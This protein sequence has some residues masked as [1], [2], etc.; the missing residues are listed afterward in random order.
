MRKVL[1]VI[2]L[3]LISTPITSLCDDDF[4]LELFM[5]AILAGAVRQGESQV[6]GPEGGMFE[7]AN[8]IILSVPSGALTQIVTI[9]IKNLDCAEIEPIIQAPVI[10][11]LEKRCLFGFVAKPEGLTFETPVTVS[12]PVS[13]LAEGERVIWT[14]ID[15]GAGTYFIPSAEMVFRGKEGM[16]DVSVEHFSTKGLIA[17]MSKDS[18]YQYWK[19]EEPAC[20]NIYPTPFDSCC[21]I[22]KPIQSEGDIMSGANC[23]DCQISGKNVRTIFPLCP[24]QPEFW[25]EISESTALCPEDLL[26]VIKSVDSELWICQNMSLEA[27]LLGTNDDGSECSLP[28]PVNWSLTANSASASLS[29]QGP[30][31]AILRGL[32]TGSATV[33]VVSTADFFVNTTKNFNFHTISGNWIEKFPNWS[34]TCTIGDYSWEETGGPDQWVNILEQTCTATSNTLT[35]RPEAFPGSAPFSGSLV[36]SGNPTDPFS[37][38]LSVASS[39]TPDC[40]VFMESEGGDIIFGDESMCPP[41]AICTALSCFESESGSGTFSSAK[42]ARSRTSESSGHFEATWEELRVDSTT[43]AVETVTRSI[44]CE[45][46]ATSSGQK[47]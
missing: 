13:S 46:Q 21:I 29:E 20:N 10:S 12:L 8:G 14:E 11:S 23:Q 30:N 15:T 33:E 47:L 37:F 44:T 7:F 41:D 26:P 35:S 34:E 39:N 1:L 22:S 28:M 2:L 18:Q 6:V 27:R 24:G 45:G 25:D 5:P 3:F 19:G 9:S 4:P 17:G 40:N 36:E 38:T 32:S 31:N 16:V 42:L 43:G